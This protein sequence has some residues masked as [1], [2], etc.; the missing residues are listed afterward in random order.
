MAEKTKN[1]LL[2]LAVSN[3][4]ASIEDPADSIKGMIDAASRRLGVAMAAVLPK[5]AEQ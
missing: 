4:T 2:R 3:K 5:G 1:N